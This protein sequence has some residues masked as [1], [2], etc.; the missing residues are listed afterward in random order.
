ML[1]SEKR[2]GK[3]GCEWKRV[4]AEVY[5][6]NGTLADRLFSP[7]EE[8]LREEDHVSL[9][10]RREVAYN[11]YTYKLFLFGELWIVRLLFIVSQMQL[12]YNVV[13]RIFSIFN[14]RYWMDVKN[15]AKIHKFAFT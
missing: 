6:E 9:I 1:D 8:C 3:H 13:N 14:P 12:Q 7:Y 5:G 4:I 11:E 15:G 2:T 10:I